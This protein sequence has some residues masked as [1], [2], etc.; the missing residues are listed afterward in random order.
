MDNP[1]ELSANGQCRFHVT[2]KQIL[3]LNKCQLC[4]DLAQWP[5]IALEL[6]LHC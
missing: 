1:A 3:S 6:R 4:G 5:E 2:H